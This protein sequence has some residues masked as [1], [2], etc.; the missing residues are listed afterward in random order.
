MLHRGSESIIG[1]IERV[2]R[3]AFS[4]AALEFSMIWGQDLLEERRPIFPIEPRMG[5]R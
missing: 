4:A 2:D 1:S 3:L 5:F